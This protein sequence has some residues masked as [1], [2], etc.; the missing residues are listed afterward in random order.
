MI[1][2]T[3]PKVPGY[4]IVGTMRIGRMT[5]ARELLGVMISLGTREEM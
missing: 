5:I 1:L 4:L 2:L 3:F